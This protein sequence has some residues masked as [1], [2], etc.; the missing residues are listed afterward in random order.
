MERTPVPQASLPQS[1]QNVLRRART[2][3]RPSEIILFGSRA[4]E[5]ASETSD[6]DFAFRGVDDEAGWTQFHN[7]VIHEAPTLFGIDLV[8]YEKAS[9]ELRA[10]IDLEGRLVIESA[11]A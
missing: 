5:N 2:D 1:V 10:R 6:F 4:R 11:A 8:R 7:Y 3:L 9:E